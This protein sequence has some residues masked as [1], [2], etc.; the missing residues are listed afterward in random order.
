[1]NVYLAGTTNTAQPIK[2]KMI[3]RYNTRQRDDGGENC[4]RGFGE[5]LIA[6]QVFADRKPDLMKGHHDMQALF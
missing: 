2:I 6:F 1:M 3:I 5:D 4:W